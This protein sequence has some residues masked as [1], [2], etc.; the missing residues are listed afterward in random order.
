MKL[1]KFERA[2]NLKPIYIN[3][4]MIIDVEEIVYGDGKSVRRIKCIGSSNHGTY[5]D[6]E[7]T[8]EIVLDR[9]Y[10]LN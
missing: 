4:T 2:N 10:H 1:V 7:D 5:H 8:I 3:P 9:L 6:V